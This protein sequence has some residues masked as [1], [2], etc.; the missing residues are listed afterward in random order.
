MWNAHYSKITALCVTRDDA[1]L[2]TG[3]EDGMIHVWA[4]AS[5]LDIHYQYK[6]GGM[7]ELFARRMFTLLNLFPRKRAVLTYSHIRKS[8][9]ANHFIVVRIRG[10]KLKDIFNISRQ[11]CQSF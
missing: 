3:G 5:L 10:G 9:I 4:L 7:W 6:A 8:Y 1:H 2:L 11:I